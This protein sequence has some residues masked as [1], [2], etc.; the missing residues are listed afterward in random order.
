MEFHLTDDRRMLADSLARFLAES[1][2][3]EK[4]ADI[5]YAAPFHDPAAL[6]GLVELGV[7]YALAGEDQGGM[8]GTG[9]DIAVVFETLG[10]AL[11]P[12][13]ILPALLAA[14][15]LSAAEADL[16]PLLTGA[17]RYSVGLGELD[18]PY[19]LSGI[20]TQARADGD[21]WRLTGRKSVVYGGQVADRLL[22]AAR[23]A[24]GLAV[25]EVAAADAEVVGYAMIDGGG[26]AEVILD[27]TKA[28]L[29]LEDAEAA[30]QGALDA[31]ALA[32]AAEALG[33]MEA[34][35][36]VLVDYLKTR[37]QFGQPIGAFQALQHRAV[38]LAIE[39]EQARSIVIRAADGLDA[40]D[41]SRRVSQAKHLV[42]RI[43]RL[44]SEEAIQMH[45]GI[46]MTWDYPVSHFAKRLVMIDHQLGDADFHLERLMTALQ[47]EA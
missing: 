13:P 27:D 20:V 24:T 10:H 46:A 26:A 14:R 43:A 1:C 31:G 19:D 12:E 34:T 32:L 17:V 18:A 28:M 4:R 40:P 35:N 30:L 25:F 41:G 38:D 2:P 37:K 29:V 16:E 6:E 8:G 44:V 45:G 3:V 7:L 9:F 42:G 36:A 22:I 33:A 15:L 23:S 21:A 39:I 5:A 11:C 47:A